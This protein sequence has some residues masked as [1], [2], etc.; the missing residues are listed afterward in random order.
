MVKPLKR[1]DLSKGIL[2]ISDFSK[3]T[4]GRHVKKNQDSV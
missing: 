2:V 3:S 4:W 1:D